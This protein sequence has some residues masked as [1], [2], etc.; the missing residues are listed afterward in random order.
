VHVPLA[1]WEPR[2]FIIF[3]FCDLKNSVIFF[4]KKT[5]NLVEFF[6]KKKIQNY[7]HFFGSKNENEMMPH[8]GTSYIHTAQ[9]YPGR[10]V[11]VGGVGVGRCTRVVVGADWC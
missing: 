2:F 4:L 5:A 1:T 3:Q 6:S 11:F 9:C 10:K 8:M 7:P